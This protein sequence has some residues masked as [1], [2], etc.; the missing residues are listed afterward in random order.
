MS[1]NVNKIK[2]GDCAHFDQQYKYK[3]NQRLPV[4]YGWCRKLSVY[5]S[6]PWDKGSAPPSDAK[7]AAKGE[8]SNPHVVTG[9]NVIPSCIHAQ[10]S[11]G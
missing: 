4:W 5:P 9:D 7:V 3:N 11:G 8:P 1:G 10:K 2:C 6:D